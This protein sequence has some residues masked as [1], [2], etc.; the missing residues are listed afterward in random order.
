MYYVA[1]L[2]WLRLEALI[3][4][5]TESATRRHVVRNVGTDI[6]VIHFAFEPLVPME[7]RRRML[8]FWFL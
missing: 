7:I 6:S 4:A 3:V 1:Q 2:Q 8:Q 5:I